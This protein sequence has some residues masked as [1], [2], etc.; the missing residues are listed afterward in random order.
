MIFNEA[1]VLH[2]TVYGTTPFF[3]D[4]IVLETLFLSLFFLICILIAVVKRL[5][6]IVAYEI[7]ATQQHVNIFERLT[8]ETVQA[9]EGVLRR[10]PVELYEHFSAEPLESF[11]YL[12][13][14][15]GKVDTICIIV[16]I[17][18]K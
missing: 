18:L 11:F 16:F 10:A 8:R 5:V 9:P 6:E 12:F 4:Q 2:T 7:R 3:D 13:I 17:V 15:M 1:P 14:E